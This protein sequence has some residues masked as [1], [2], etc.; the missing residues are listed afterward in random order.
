MSKI[1]QSTKTIR[2]NAISKLSS[3]QHPR[4]FVNGSH[5]VHT[6]HNSGHTSASGHHGDLTSHKSDHSSAATAQRLEG[7]RKNSLPE[8]TSEPSVEVKRVSPKASKETQCSLP[9]TGD[10]PREEQFI[11]SKLTLRKSDL[12]TSCA[13]CASYSLSAW[14]APS[15]LHL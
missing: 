15:L 1:H 2:L 6:G 8:M 10:S 4:L 11:E 3:L 5:S 13:N 14:T 7:S 12:R 9:L